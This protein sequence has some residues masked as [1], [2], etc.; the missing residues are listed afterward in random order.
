M[1]CR[2]TVE[3]FFR[4]T[5]NWDLFQFINSLLL[6]DLTAWSWLRSL[7][8]TNSLSCDGH[9]I[10]VF[11][12]N[13]SKSGQDTLFYFCSTCSKKIRCKMINNSCHGFPCCWTSCDGIQNFLRCSIYFCPHTRFVWD[14]ACIM[15]LCSVIFVSRFAHATVLSRTRNS[16]DQLAW[17]TCHNYTVPC[18]RYPTSVWEPHSCHM[19]VSSI[20]QQCMEDDLVLVVGDIQHHGSHHKIVLEGKLFWD[21]YEK[22]PIF[23]WLP[24]GNS[25]E[26][27]VLWKQGNQS[28]SILSVCLGNLSIPIWSL[29][30]GIVLFV[31]L[32]GEHPSSGH[33][34]S[35]LEL[36]HVDEIKKPRCQPRICTPDVSLQQTVC[37]ILYF[38]GWCFFSC[39]RPHLGSCSCCPSAGSHASF[40]H[41]SS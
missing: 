14:V 37:S 40:Q 35:G 6:T 24:C 9:I 3:I 26:I 19:Q 5:F 28:V 29:L 11:R 34:L 15:P 41:V 18:Q 27:W 4:F 22:D 1:H 31:R 13:F 2:G 8:P 21:Q 10:P 38:L 17:E 39:T 16:I 32:D 36:P 30:W 20:L 12:T 23:C 7:R 33:I 25:S